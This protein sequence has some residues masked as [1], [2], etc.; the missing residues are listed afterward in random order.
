MKLL[1][2]LA[3]AIVL[4]SAP[5][6]AAYIDSNLAVSSAAHMNGGGCYPIAKY[7]GF[8]DQLNTINPEW[9]AIDV[10]SHTPP[11]ADPI[12][13]AGRCSSRRTGTGRS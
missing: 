13:L 3:A 8:T 5:A 9:A 4:S 1:A 11:E 10:G 2:L 6:S 12:T 7:P